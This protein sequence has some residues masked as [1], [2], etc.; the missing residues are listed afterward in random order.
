MSD[1]MPDSDPASAPSKGDDARYVLLAVQEDRML[2]YDRENPR[3]WIRSTEI[4]PLA[5]M[6]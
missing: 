1:G 4:R 6:R 5:E 3:A 2:M